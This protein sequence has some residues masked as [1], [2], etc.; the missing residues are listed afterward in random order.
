M[1][2]VEAWYPGRGNYLFEWVCGGARDIG[3]STRPEGGVLV[4]EILR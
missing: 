1:F 2:G 4:D 3:R